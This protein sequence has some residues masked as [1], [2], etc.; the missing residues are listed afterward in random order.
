MN[1]ADAVGM[2]IN[3]LFS[4]HFVVPLYQRN[5]AWRTDEIQQFLQDIWDAFQKNKDKDYYIGSI[6]VMRRHDGSFEVIDGQQRLTVISLLAIL[7]GKLTRP[8]LFFDSRPEVQRFFEILQLNSGKSDDACALP[9]PSLFYLKEACEFIKNSLVTSKNEDGAYTQET[10]LNGKVADFF[11]EHV[12]LVRNIVPEDTDVAAYFEIMNNRG[13]QLQKHE[14]VKSQMMAKIE[15]TDKRHQ[16]EFAKIWDACAQMDVPIQRLF[17][18]DDR[19]KYFGDYY[20][21]FNFCGKDENTQSVEDDPEISFDDIFK[22]D[23]SEQ[24]C[25]MPSKDPN[26][27]DDTMQS[28]KETYGSIIDFPNF[29]MHVLRLYLRFKKGEEFNVYDVPLNEKELLSEYKNYMDDKD[30]NSID[31]VKHLLFC[32]TIF[33][34]FIVKSTAD[35]KDSDDGRKWVMIKPKKEGDNWYF[36]SSFGNENGELLVKA[37]S[38]LQVTFSNRVYK[39]WLYDVLSCLYDKCRL[40][41]ADASEN[42]NIFNNVDVRDYLGV[43]HDWMSKYYHD[44]MSKYYDDNSPKWMRKCD[45]D[46][47]P[48]ITLLEKGAM[49]SE[50]NSYSP[51]TSVPHFLLNFIDYLYYCENLN[52]QQKNLNDFEFKYWNSVEHHLAQN[53]ADEAAKQYVDNLGNLYLISNNAN[54]RLSDRVVQE[55]VEF[56]ADKNMGPNRQVI[57]AMTRNNNFKWGGELI[58]EHYNEIA[59][60]LDNHQTILSSSLLPRT[61]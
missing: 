34:R 51:G 24:K 15:N 2:S 16:N 13:E 56:Y 8:I 29:L 1:N 28:E 48:K 49:P 42:A 22:Q 58:A 31:F 20:D 46:N 26:K 37:V 57:Y 36:V 11:M 45:D 9:E 17:S 50:E 39:T 54:S 59:T 41:D 4:N 40:K 33:D 6:V 12:V 19:I 61:T 35:A 30:F 21:S 18:S 60:L 53:K 38:M 25:C 52:N 27:E 10:F 14:I 7:M 44:W 47:S 5:F 43:L 23:D 55:K 32:R 3:G